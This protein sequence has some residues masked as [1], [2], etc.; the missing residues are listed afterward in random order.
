LKPKVLFVC[1]GNSC[2]SI[3]AEA[4]TR[5]LC[6]ERWQMASAGLSPLGWVA[7]ETTEVLTEMAVDTA[8]LYS[9]GLTEIRL[10]E[11][12]LIIN[13]SQY[14]L[15]RVLPPESAAKV[16]SR[17]MPDPFGGSLEAYRRSLA[18]IKEMILRE[19]CS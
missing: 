18:A 19:L 11:F 12:F 17:P 15:S 3:M 16:I 13:L 7:P 14:S 2:R 5:H 1:L 9:K 8:G 4:L 6:G 10:Q